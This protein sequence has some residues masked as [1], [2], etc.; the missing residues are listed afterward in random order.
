MFV[1]TTSG[2]PSHRLILS[3]GSG[4]QLPLHMLLDSRYGWCDDSSL[5]SQKP[6]LL[7][8]TLPHHLAFTLF[9]CPFLLHQCKIWKIANVTLVW[10]FWQL[11]HSVNP[12]SYFCQQHQSAFC[13]KSC[14]PSWRQRYKVRNLTS[15]MK[16]SALSWFLMLL[17]VT[18]VYMAL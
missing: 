11:C 1:M 5:C 3:T 10:S 8:D 9:F 15:K 16:F 7:S 17:P 4:S 12:Q 6:L 13:G 2:H 18:T 14:M